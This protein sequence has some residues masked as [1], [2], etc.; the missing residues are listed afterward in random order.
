VAPLALGYA[1]LPLGIVVG[2][3]MRSAPVRREEG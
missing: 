2:Q 1:A 3:L